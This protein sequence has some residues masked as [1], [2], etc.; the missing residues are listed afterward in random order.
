MYGGWEY[1]TISARWGGS[2][3]LL[4]PRSI[5]GNTLPTWE[6]GPPLADYICELG[7]EGWELVSEWYDHNANTAAG[8]CWQYSWL[9]TDE[10]WQKVTIG[11]RTYEGMEGYFEYIG[12]MGKERWE[13][14]SAA[15]QSLSVADPNVQL[16]D[17]QAKYF[18]PW[19]LIFKKPVD[20]SAVNLR[21]KRPRQAP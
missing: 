17:S 20:E 12:Q 9:W 10:A 6:E 8:V 18:G 3:N 19:L 4:R 14:V 11:N 21:F 7:K 1:L 15:P 5:N 16:Y 2:G 13:L